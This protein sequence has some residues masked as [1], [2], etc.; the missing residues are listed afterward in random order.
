M[1]DRSGPGVGSSG[2]AAPSAARRHAARLR[3]RPRRPRPRATP[4]ATAQSS[5][6][7][8]PSPR[9]RR[10]AV[11]QRDSNSRADRQRDR[12][13]N[14]DTRRDQTATPPPSA[15]GRGLG[16]IASSA[17]LSYSRWQSRR[18]SQASTP[19]TRAGWARSMGSH[20]RGQRFRNFER[21]VLESRSRADAVSDAAGKERWRVRGWDE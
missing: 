10:H 12:H 14:A 3:Q 17:G 9:R 1:I 16:L 13:A 11:R 4:S 15:S 8:T 6:S 2:N 21:H 5:P 7:A 19:R 20:R 18:P